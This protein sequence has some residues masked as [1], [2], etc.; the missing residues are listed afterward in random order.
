[1]IYA[2]YRNTALLTDLSDV[3]C[4]DDD[5]KV[6]STQKVDVMSHKDACRVPQ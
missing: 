2:T 4:F 1:M 5:N 6:G 3:P